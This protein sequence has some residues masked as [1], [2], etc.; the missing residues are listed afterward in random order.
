MERRFNL[1]PLLVCNSPHLLPV[2]PLATPGI[3]QRHSVLFHPSVGVTLGWRTV[4]R[5]GLR[6][7]RFWKL[8]ADDPPSPA[9]PVFRQVC[10]ALLSIVGT[11]VS[12]PLSFYVHFFCE[13]LLLGVREESPL[14]IVGGVSLSFSP[15][16]FGGWRSTDGRICGRQG[17]RHSRSFLLP[18]IPKARPALGGVHGA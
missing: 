12:A 11:R 2:T 8:A 15:F 13:F 17:R 5:S 14:H 6:A 4:I 3:E 16:S 10:F 9:F 1:G 18:E 7:A